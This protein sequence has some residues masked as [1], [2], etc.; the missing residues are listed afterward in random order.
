MTNIQLPDR[1]FLA[2]QLLGQIVKASTS[3]GESVEFRFTE[4][5]EEVAEK[6]GLPNSVDL[7]RELSNCS[8]TLTNDAGNKQRFHVF[9]AWS[10]DGEVI[11][12]KLTREFMN[13]PGRIKYVQ[14]YE[15]SKLSAV[16][17]DIRMLH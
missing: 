5:D 3:Y 17:V 2:Y 6:A 8:V 13:W 1:F 4:E 14:I 15:E 12:V 10:L 7:I 16:T 9:E 11:S